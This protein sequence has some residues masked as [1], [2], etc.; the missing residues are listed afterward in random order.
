MQNVSY[1]PRPW[2]AAAPARSVAAHRAVSWFV[3]LTGAVMASG[4]VVLI[5]PAPIDLALVALLAVG[6]AA[7]QL[8]FVRKHELPVFLLGIFTIAN[9]VSLPAAGDMSRA[10]Y[11]FSITAYML[12]WTAFFAGFVT[13]HGYAGFSAVMNGYA[14]AGMLSSVLGTLSYLHV[15]GMQKLLLL[16]GRPKGLFKDPNVYGPYMVPLLLWALVRLQDRGKTGAQ[17][18]YWSLVSV[19]AVGGIFWSFSRACWINTVVSILAY[20]AIRLF[21]GT[22][23]KRE[24]GNVFRVATAVL[25]LGGLLLLGGKRAD[26]NLGTMLEDRLGSHGLKQYDTVRFHTQR[27]SWEAV[28]ERPLGIGPGQAEPVFQYSSHSLY[29]RT[30]SENGFLGFLSMMAFL[31]V[32]LW[33]ALV[34]SARAAD[35]RWRTCFTILAACLI[36]L[37]VNSLVIDTL[38]WRHFFMLL[39]LIWAS[40]ADLL[41]REARA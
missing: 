22:L 23:T 41:R 5:E 21:A 19:A 18:L 3:V 30:L 17:T 25:V 28:L 12:T 20:L 9:L 6:F 35:E 24:L 40:P 7:A 10:L 13:R 14:V 37:L 33:R 8:A 26:R 38:H 11:F 29:L 27:L 32:S 39:G 36:G 31:V 16:Y 15:V 1:Y 34:L 2:T 4:A